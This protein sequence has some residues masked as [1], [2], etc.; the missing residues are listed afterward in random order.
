MEYNPDEI[1]LRAME[2]IRRILKPSGILSINFP[3]SSSQLAKAYSVME[4]CMGTKFYTYSFSQ[5]D[6][7]L[8]DTGFEIREFSNIG[9]AFVFI[10]RAK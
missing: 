2:E 4:E 3:D 8:C 7:I 10:A 9:M 6:R 1:V 5:I